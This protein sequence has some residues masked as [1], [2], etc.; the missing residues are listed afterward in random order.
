MYKDLI[1]ASCTTVQKINYF[2]TGIYFT[3]ETRTSF[4]TK[5]THI[6]IYISIYIK[7]KT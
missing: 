7:C 6:Y 5:N 1:K 2:Q 3:N 4:Y